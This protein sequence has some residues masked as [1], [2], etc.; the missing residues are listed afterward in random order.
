MKGYAPLVRPWIKAGLNVLLMESEERVL[1]L[2]ADS[3][4]KEQAQ[5]V[6]ASA[7]APA[8]RPSAPP[9]YAAPAR[10]AP[11]PVP[12]VPPVPA[13]PKKAA[14]APTRPLQA[15]RGRSP[16]S[17]LAAPGALPPERWPAA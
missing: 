7:P 11:S 1:V 2:R 8:F 3:G 5:S 12:A 4:G 16:Q 10:P 15:A 14:P 13:E 9:R 17:L 6:P